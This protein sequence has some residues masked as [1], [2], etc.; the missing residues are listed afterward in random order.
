M[1]RY[2]PTPFPLAFL[3]PSP[4]RPQEQTPGKD[5]KTKGKVYAAR[6]DQS[7]LYGQVNLLLPASCVYGCNTAPLLF[8]HDNLPD[9]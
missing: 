9:C 5:K 7:E 1:L 2:P 8:G 4:P 3:A 6:R